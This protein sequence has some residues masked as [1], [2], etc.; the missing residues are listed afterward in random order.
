MSGYSFSEIETASFLPQEDWH[1]IQKPF[2][3]DPQKRREERKVEDNFRLTRDSPTI[4][5]LYGTYRY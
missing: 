5:K 1:F 3:D 4:S 2:T